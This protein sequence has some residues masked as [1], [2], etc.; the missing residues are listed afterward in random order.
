MIENL[1]GRNEGK[2][3]E[4][5]EST[6]TLKGIIKAVIAFA[7]TAGGDIVIGVKDK[8]KEIVGLKDVLAEEERIASSIAESITP[9]IRPD[10]EI[11]TYRNKEI[12]VVRVH[13][14]AGPFYIKAD[15]PEKG[16]YVRFGSTNRVADNETINSL[17]L[18]AR[19]M[20]FDELPNIRGSRDLLDW[21]AIK[22]AFGDV[23]KTI[24]D[25]KCLA[26][27]VLVEHAGKVYPSYGGI[28]LFGTKRREFF[29]DA[30]VRCARFKGTERIHFLDTITI[31]AHLNLVLGKVSDF[32][33]KHITIRSVIGKIKRTDI[34]QYPEIAIREVIINALL[35]TD[36]A[37]RGATITVAIFDDRI[38]VAN[39][40]GLPFGM[41]LE[42]VLGGASRI[43]NHVIARIFNELGLIEQWGTGL[44]KI[45]DACKQHGLA[46]PLFQ[47]INNHFMVTIYSGS[48]NT[49][50]VRPWQ[51]KIIEHIKVHGRISAKE[52]AVL[53][54]INIRTTREKMKQLI[55]DGIIQRIGTSAKDPYA[56]YILAEGKQ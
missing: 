2:T 16:V 26:M 33:N 3:L 51:Q 55:N 48:A 53:W 38:E 27:N 10:I 46:T 17:R 43:R 37:M 15:G 32:I 47:E 31:D 44:N 14:G 11:H 24:T 9:L 54:K 4:F 28:I 50:T 13:H 45:I 25:P 40:G 52:A 23:H 29:P 49:K 34:P 36:Y 35:H 8:T 1:L 21:P 7:N 19:N 12:I 20:T 22:E 56:V 18:L 41:T 42:R 39:P 6:Q 30:I 5:K